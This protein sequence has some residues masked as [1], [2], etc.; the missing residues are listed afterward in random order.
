MTTTFARPVTR[1]ALLAAAVL[2]SSRE[3]GAQGTG[4]CQRRL[5][6]FDVAAFT[7]NVTDFRLSQ[8]E[9]S[10]HLVTIT[11]RF[12]NKLSRP[13]ALGYV[14]GSGIV[15][16]D[17]GNRYQVS[18]SNAVR[19]IGEIASTFDPKFVLQ[20]GESS[21]ARFELLLQ[22]NAIL[23]TK[24]EMDLAV[25]EIDPVAGNQ[26]R[27][28]KEH[29]LHFRE[30]GSGSAVASA[31][32]TAAPAPAPTAAPLAPEIDQC[33]GKTR[34]YSAGPFVAEIDGISGTN[35]G[36]QQHHVLS[37]NVRVRNVGTQPLILAYKAYSGGA[38]DNLGNHYYWGRAG[39]HDMSA[40]G[41][42]LLASTSADPQFQLAPGE[43][44]M[45]KFTLTRYDA[46]GHELG[47]SWTYDLTLTSLEITPSRQVRVG[48]D[49]AVSFKEIGSTA[50]DQSK[51]AGNAA[52]ARLIDAFRKK[53]TKP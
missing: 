35:V 43:S 37:I 11:V 47:T 48:R 19:G 7:A 53:V 29:A 27:L 17:Q 44:R 46:K 14:K 38:T 25:R 3:G 31:G 32:P 23:G 34:C 2:L 10:M 21:D 26:F 42:G 15:T 5:D 28:G 33:A 50:G 49:Y 4:A 18:G 6:C 52:A 12:Q 13:L 30:L 39:T 16:D 40:S 20:P 51:A 9:R 24:Y 8:A 22:S 1:T 41:I 45:A 36:N